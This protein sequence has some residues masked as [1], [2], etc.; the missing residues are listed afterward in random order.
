M[1]EDHEAQQKVDWDEFL[2][3][4]ITYTDQWTNY[5]AELK[6]YT[7][8]QDEIV[9]AE[10]DLLDYQTPVP[11][12]YNETNRM[13]KPEEPTKLAEPNM[14]PYPPASTYEFES[15][16]RLYMNLTKVTQPKRWK[17]LQENEM[18]T[19][20]GQVQVWWEI[21]EKHHEDL[22]AIEQFEDDDEDILLKLGLQPKEESK[23]KKKMK[24]SK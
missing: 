20:K 13:K 7:D 18:T 8:E 3:K 16:G 11:D 23:K 22:I 1:K 19:K 4:N 12:K 21:H 24:K 17:R 14:G 9:E 15:V 5:T 10:A 6:K 2:I